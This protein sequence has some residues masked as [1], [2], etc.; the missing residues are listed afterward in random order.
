MQTRTTLTAI[1][2]VAAAAGTA[3]AAPVQIQVTV[4][5]LAPTNSVSFAPLRLAFNNGSYDSF[6][7][8]QAATAPIISIAEGGSG[9]DW[10]PAFMAAD[11]T[12]TLGTVVPDPAGPLLPGQ[13][14]TAVFDVDSS[15][16][17][18]FTFGAMVVPSNDYFIG[19]DS[20]TQYR[21]LDAD[22]NLLISSITQRG[23][24]IWDAG[25]ELDGPF[26][27]AFLVGSNNDD[28]I[29][30]NGVVSFD[31]EGL[32]VF[33]GLETA[34]GYTFDRQFGADDAVYRIS[35]AVVPAPG[36]VGTL[37]LAGL[38][39]ARRRRA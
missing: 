32:D 23:R 30:Q 4:E 9:A 7:N 10:F 3:A 33:N 39:A 13:T 26:G 8:G 15:I 35:F 6:N 16:N 31:F 17:Q 5:N 14:G 25:S 27:A 2:L 36:V 21:I 18:F 19:N 22:G 28:R 1:A 34:A 20:P 37:G 29:A 24:D 38:V 11:P 12:A